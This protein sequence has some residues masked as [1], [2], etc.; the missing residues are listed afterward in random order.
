MA[1]MASSTWYLPDEKLSYKNYPELN[2]VATGI[3]SIIA[4]AKT[5]NTA[6]ASYNAGTVDKIDVN[7]RDVTTYIDLCRSVTGILGNAPNVCFDL[8]LEIRAV[9]YELQNL[10]YNKNRYGSKYIG[11][12]SNKSSLIDSNTI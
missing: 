8:L 4:Y 9:Q 2:T 6:I 7:M 10:V 5:V 1:I 3:N 11:T 12:P